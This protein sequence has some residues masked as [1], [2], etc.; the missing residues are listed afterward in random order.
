MVTPSDEKRSD[1]P[2]LT[3]PSA[4]RQHSD[5]V[6]GWLPRQA[7]RRAWRTV[8]SARPHATEPPAAFTATGIASPL[9]ARSVAKTE[10][11][12]CDRQVRAGPPV[13]RLSQSLGAARS[14][15]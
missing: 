5:H 8:L 3:R 2:Q 12:T 14:R 1:M 6:G 15:W 9:Q 7:D 13:K 11:D 10:H 4:N